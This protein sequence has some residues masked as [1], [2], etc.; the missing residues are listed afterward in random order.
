SP[1]LLAALTK[2]TRYVVAAL[3]QKDAAGQNLAIW[4]LGQVVV[5]SDVVTGSGD[6]PVEELTFVFG[7]ARQ[8]LSLDGNPGS[9]ITTTWSQVNTSPSSEDIP[10]QTDSYSPRITV[11][12]GPFIYDGTAHPAAA[13]AMSVYGDAVSGTFTF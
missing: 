4:D 13:A 11:H 12:A 8:V 3:I 7:A 2:G 5:T 10:A 1:T 9:A 6:L